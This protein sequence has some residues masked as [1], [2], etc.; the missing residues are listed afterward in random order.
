[1]FRKKEFVIATFVTLALTI[2]LSSAFVSARPIDPTEGDLNDSKGNGD[3]LSWAISAGVYGHWM[4]LW[5]LRPPWIGITETECWGHRWAIGW[6]VWCEEDLLLR[7]VIDGVEHRLTNPGTDA[8]T[9]LLSV[10]AHTVM[11]QAESRFGNIWG[12]H[13]TG[14]SGWAT[15][16]M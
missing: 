2:V 9:N 12:Q 14:L 10:R 7:Y 13:W 8:D 11:C 3:G 15:I 5:M 1:L 6:P 16:N 4:W